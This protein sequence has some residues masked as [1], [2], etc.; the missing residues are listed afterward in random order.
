MTT[1]A[2]L[3][4]K[5]WKPWRSPRVKAH[6]D[7]YTL[8]AQNSET[9][10]VA[11]CKGMTTVAHLELTI[12]KPWRSPRAKARDENCTL[13]VELDIRKPRRSPRVKAGDDGCT[14]GA[15]NSETLEVSTCKGT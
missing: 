13:G 7:S 8:G 3:E 5:F 14:L 4:L 11:T 12:R 9:L 10:E 6:G 15:R 1:V 2:H